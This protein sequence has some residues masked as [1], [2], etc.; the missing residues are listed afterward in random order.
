MSAVLHINSQYYQLVHSVWGLCS[1]K[2]CQIMLGS[3]NG[4]IAGSWSYVQLSQSTPS[5]CCASL[6]P[7]VLFFIPQSYSDWKWEEGTKRPVS[8]YLQ[9]TYFNLKTLPNTSWTVSKI[10]QWFR[11]N[12]MYIMWTVSTSR[13]YQDFFLIAHPMLLIQMSKGYRNFN[14]KAEAAATSWQEANLNA[15]SKPCNQRRR[16]FFYNPIKSKFWFA[17]NS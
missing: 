5:L 11:D 10:L 9:H 15:I 12:D 13:T 7:F 1:W 2:S 8:V 6:F 14:I 17:L 3:G 16:D 4:S